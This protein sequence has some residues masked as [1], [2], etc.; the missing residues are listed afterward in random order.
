MVDALIMSTHHGRVTGLRGQ[1]FVEDANPMA[2]KTAMWQR[3][4]R[5]YSSQQ[6][7]FCCA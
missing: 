7:V 3:A 6:Q 4:S 2:S 5:S 1:S